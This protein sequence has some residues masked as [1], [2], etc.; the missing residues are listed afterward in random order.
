MIFTPLIYVLNSKFEI[1][2]YP[3]PEIYQCHNSY[4]IKIPFKKYGYKNFWFP[5]IPKKNFNKITFK[6]AVYIPR[7]IIQS[8]FELILR[9]GETLKNLDYIYVYQIASGKHDFLNFSICKK[10]KFSLLTPESQKTNPGLRPEIDPIWPRLA[11][12]L[13]SFVPSRPFCSRT[14]QLIM[15]R[16][17]FKNKQ[18][19]KK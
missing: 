1:S 15:H 19:W 17:I 13:R 3:L 14:I 7:K 5:L 12:R 11:F 2:N 16:D 6:W 18:W 4:S 8:P 10:V 9:E